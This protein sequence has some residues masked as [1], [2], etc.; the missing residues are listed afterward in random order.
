MI[1]KKIAPA[2]K[3]LYPRKNAV[4]QDDGASIHRTQHVLETVA[5]NFCSR[6]PVEE[7]APKMADI[8]PI[9]NVWSIIKPSL[10]GKDIQNLTEL[11]NAIKA[12]WSRTSK[13]KRLCRRLIESIPAR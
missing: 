11:R 2:V 8:W 1:R 12:V 10:D 3:S 6:I 7:Q 4:W 13:D 9:E 5:Q